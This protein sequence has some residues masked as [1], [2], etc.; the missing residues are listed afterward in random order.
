MAEELKGPESVETDASGDWDV[1]GKESTEQ[2]AQVE[3]EPIPVVDPDEKAPPEKKED[4]SEEEEPSQEAVQTGEEEEEVQLSERETELEKENATYKAQIDHANKVAAYYEA[5]ANEALGVKPE[6]EKPT[7][8]T[9]AGKE[10]PEALEEPPDEFESTQQVAQFF[11]NRIKAQVGS[12][13]D[14]LLDQA[15][16][17]KIKPVFDRVNAVV[18]ALQEHVIKLLHPDFKEVTKATM[19]EVFVFPPDGGDPIGVKNQALL[20]YLQDNP[21]PQ[22]AAYEYGM[23][24]GVP[25]KIK[26][27]SDKKTDK[28][29][30]K[31]GA[32][33]KG[34]T[35]IEGT[36]K[37]ES[38]D[39]LGWEETAESRDA[40]LHKRG[41]I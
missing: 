30:K 34:P 6:G 40:K 33:P 35:K 29:L 15:Y 19:E 11:D 1:E 22:L 31:I 7:V 24:K 4:I 27:E 16:D 37:V 38:D 14:P 10:A 26:E 13:V 5:K 8:E 20:S 25:K 28:L 36:S 18:G 12:L 3:A 32:K 23:S 39:E 41:H 2:E 21:F 17:A 9:P